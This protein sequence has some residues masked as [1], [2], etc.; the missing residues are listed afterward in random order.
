MK[1]RTDNKGYTLLFAVIMATLVLTVA[2]FIVSVSRKQ[3]ILSSSA[4]DS[5]YAFYAADSGAECAILHLNDFSTTTEVNIQCNGLTLIAKP[6]WRFDPSEP[7][8]E[9]KSGQSATTTFFMPVVVNAAQD[10][11]LPAG[12]SC[13]W[14]NVG[15][16][17]N[18]AGNQITII[19]S[20][21]YNIGW[22]GNPNPQSGEVNGTCD[23]YGP[24]KVERALKF[25]FI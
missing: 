8:Y 25:T 12:N 18:Q 9:A 15:Y 4:R 2:I 16:N 1:L 13:V 6:T 7:Y 20:R 24:R 17:F 5:T 3:F 22:N 14:V 10:P 19:E 23:I 11:G 21:G